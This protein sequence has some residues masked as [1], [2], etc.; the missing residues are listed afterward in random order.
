MKKALVFFLLATFGSGFRAPSVVPEV[1]II[2]LIADPARYDATEII[3]RGFLMVEHEGNELFLSKE[4]AQYNIHSSL[5]VSYKNG[6]VSEVEAIK[7]HKQYVQITAYYNKDIRGHSGVDKGALVQ[8]KSI[9]PLRE[10][11]K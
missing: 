11:F 1:S 2:E 10:W 6:N 5:W 8:I 3:V 4:H 7:F 9:V